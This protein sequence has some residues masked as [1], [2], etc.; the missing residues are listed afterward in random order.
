MLDE[1]TFLTRMGDGVAMFPTHAPRVGET[2]IGLLVSLGCEI[3]LI[4]SSS[5][6]LYVYN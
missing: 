5:G 3:S 1:C 4:E 6:V 2:T